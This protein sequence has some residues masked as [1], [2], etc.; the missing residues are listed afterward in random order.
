M[1]R[2][3]GHQPH[4]L[5]V[6]DHQMRAPPRAHHFPRVIF[7]RNFAPNRGQFRRHDVRHAQSFERA[8]RIGLRPALPR[9]MS[10]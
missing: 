7:Q 3:G 4:Q 6:R 2:L 5:L 8:A 9:R 1:Q 10:G